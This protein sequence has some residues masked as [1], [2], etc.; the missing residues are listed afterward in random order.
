M[1]LSVVLPTKNRLTYAKES[2]LSILSINRNDFELV[3]SD[4]SDNPDL[5]NW[6]THNVNDSRL[7][8]K[9]IIGSISLSQNFQNGLDHASGVYI[10]TIGDDDTINP[11]ILDLIDWAIINN[12][13]AITP[14]FILD[15]LWP[16]LNSVKLN[17][18]V[19]ENG[20]LKI[21]FFS[22]SLFKLDVKDGIDKVVISCG[23]DLADTYYLPKIYYGIIKRKL[24]ND[25]KKTVGTNFPGISPD[26][27][28]AL[29][30]APLINNY[31]VIDYPIFIPGSSYNSA[32]GAS[33]LKKH[34]GYLENQKQFSQESIDNWPSKI[35][36]FYSVE[37][38]WSQSTFVTLSVLG[39]ESYLKKFNYNRIYATSIMFNFKYY[40]FIWKAFIKNSNFQNLICDI[41]YIYY[42]LLD[43][44]LLRLTYFCRNKINKIVSNDILFNNINN[45][46]DAQIKLT[47]Y[48]KSSNKSLKTILENV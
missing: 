2:I 38:V 21:K 6:L 30:V 40:K 36:K 13:D 1:I 29:C 10:C 44:F 35:P 19:Q 17:S 37:T 27:S 5:E 31:F 32:S 48:L 9:R 12:A 7:V 46:N 39:L 45:I 14:K 20:R 15:Y 24:L 18:N 43:L 26:L 23:M 22:S 41:L 47:D 4:N 8:Y 33:N 34:H 28:G 16:D 25:V 42:Y 11:E 3:I